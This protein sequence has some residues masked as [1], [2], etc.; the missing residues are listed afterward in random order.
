MTRSYARRLLHMWPYMASLA[1]RMGGWNL[2][3]TSL[4]VSSNRGDEILVLSGDLAR[5]LKHLR[6][7]HGRNFCLLRDYFYDGQTQ[8]VLSLDY[9]VHQGT[10]SRRI[11]RAVAAAESFLGNNA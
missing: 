6:E 4:S 10:I 5:T 11:H 7:K 3:S 1:E 9:R 8:V 2:D